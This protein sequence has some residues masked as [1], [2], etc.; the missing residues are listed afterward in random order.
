MNIESLQIPGSIND[1]V[2]AIN[3][4]ISIQWHDDNMEVTVINIQYITGVDGW[5]TRTVMY[6]HTT[7][8]R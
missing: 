6:Y 7:P 4:F 1:G 8:R 5:I 3:T 2:D